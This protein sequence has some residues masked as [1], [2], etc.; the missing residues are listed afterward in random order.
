MDGFKHPDIFD[1]AGLSATAWE[2]VKKTTSWQLDILV[3]EATKAGVKFW[4]LAENGQ[5]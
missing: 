4:Y 2:N 5:S 3:K 1:T